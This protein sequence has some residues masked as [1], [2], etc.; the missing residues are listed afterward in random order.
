[1]YSTSDLDTLSKLTKPFCDNFIV[2]S[3]VQRGSS[4]SVVYD[5][6]RAL[7]WLS[8]ANADDQEGK[9]YL[10]RV[11][12][13][14]RG[15]STGEKIKVSVADIPLS[16]VLLVRAI[17]QESIQADNRKQI[18]CAMSSG[19]A[20]FDLTE[21]LKIQYPHA[22]IFSDWRGSR[23]NQVNLHR[24]FLIAAEFFEE[25]VD[26]DVT[27]DFPGTVHIPRASRQLVK[28]G[29][30]IAQSRIGH[31]ALR[32][33]WKR[34]EIKSHRVLLYDKVIETIQQP[35]RSKES[36]LDTKL[37]RLARASTNGLRKRFAHP[38]YQ[39]NGV[40]RAEVTF[41]GDWTDADILQECD[42]LRGSV[43][44]RVIVSKSIHDHISDME[45]HVTQTI[46][47]FIPA[48]HE[49]KREAL[50]NIE[51][52]RRKHYRRGI[53]RVP[54]GQI[55][56]FR[57][58]VTNKKVGRPVCAPVDLVKGSVGSSL[59]FNSLAFETPC[60][61]PIVVAILVGGFREFMNGEL[62]ILW[63]RLAHFE[64]ACQANTGRMLVSPKI[65]QGFGS[66]CP[67]SIMTAC[68]VNPEYLDRL[69][70][71]VRSSNPDHSDTKMRLELRDSHV[72]DMS[73]EFIARSYDGKVSISC[74]PP[75][76]VQVKLIEDG[77]RKVGRPFKKPTQPLCFCYR[78]E[79]HRIPEPYQDEI[80][81]WYSQQPNKDACSIRVR[82]VESNFEYVLSDIQHIQGKAKSKLPI[83]ELPMRILAIHRRKYGRGASFEFD[84]EGLGCY[85]A[86]ITATKNLISHLRDKDGLLRD[87]WL[88]GFSASEPCTLEMD[89]YQYYLEHK[90]EESRPMSGG[91]GDPEELIT[92]VK[93][94]PDGSFQVVIKSVPTS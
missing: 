5:F 32:T 81:A 6:C 30:E 13:K 40:F 8:G 9:Y 67:K 60:N 82:V 73:V 15:S 36:S 84:L 24:A 18:L 79:I 48:V 3:L 72:D 49:M 10:T 88:K 94:E 91:K 70:L 68:G 11:F 46:A 34:D 61:T 19:R 12:D 7:G 50:R 38:A 17:I 43:V 26:I 89:G 4:L 58:G 55:L 90:R 25:F 27:Q 80:R 74:L 14:T 52:K 2:K 59:F 63:F 83:Q 51:I 35:G 28:Q 69:K 47:V 23:N 56:F 31:N 86:P 45:T 16:E 71:E 20:I 75:E 21:K 42:K 85:K 22:K 39:K 53:N 76:F 66:G 37:H 92:I 77:I 78:G 64:K 41:A 57:N 62:P 87:C 44:E 33:S 65:C 1:M 93:R 54:D 29:Y